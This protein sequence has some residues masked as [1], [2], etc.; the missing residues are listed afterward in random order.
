MPTKKTFILFI[1]LLICFSPII[2][3]NAKSSQSDIPP[4]TLTYLQTQ[5]LSDGGM[6]GLSGVSDPA[7]TA[8]AL[9]V[10]KLHMIDLADFTSIE[11]KSLLNYLTD[12]YSLYIV[13]DA[14][15]LFPGNAGLM[16]AALASFNQSP[17]DLSDNLLATL[18]PDG[19]F[20]T[21]ASKDFATGAYTDL[22]QALAILG[23]SAAGTPVPA[24]TITYL[25]NRQLEDGSW[26]NGFG[27]DPDTTAIVVISLLTSGQID[28]A[29]PSIEKALNFFRNSQLENGGWRP[30]WD[31]DSLNVDTTGWIS[32][33]L[34]TAGQDPQAWKKENATPQTAILSQLQDDGSIGGTYVNVYSTLEALMGLAS[35]PLF[36]IPATSVEPASEP[37]QESQAGLVVTFPDGSSLL[38]CVTFPG[39]SIS[40]YDLLIASGLSIDTFFDPVKGPGV[41]KIEGSGCPSDQCFCEM[42]NYWSYWHLENDTWAYSAIGAGTYHVKPETVDGWAWGDSVLPLEISFSEICSQNAPLFLPA[43]INADSE[44]ADTPSPEII[45]PTTLP[46]GPSESSQSFP[47]TFILLGGVFI[48]IIIV[49]LVAWQKNNVK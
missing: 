24:E 19:S 32:L 21:A 45:A 38:R 11:G 48:L 26:D 36:E 34:T 5:Q 49:L 30:S 18:Q 47:L 10:A 31:T 1:V 41:C 37:A 16:L 27:S 3:V 14:G 40:G 25:V 15:L 39:D 42:P 28:S 4:S 12:S 7:T 6:P 33:A 44:K 8:R 22:S 23:L 17:T 2:S 20:S 46:S 29:H 13:D 35:V 43:I 9:F